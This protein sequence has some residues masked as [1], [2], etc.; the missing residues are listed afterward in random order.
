MLMARALPD[1]R[2]LRVVALLFGRAQLRIFPNATAGWSDDAWEYAT[3]QKAV[4]AA[5]RWNGEGEPTGWE[6]HHRTGRH[7]PGGNPVKEWVEP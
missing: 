5:W 1:G 4:D 2:V 3:H 7:R 6:V